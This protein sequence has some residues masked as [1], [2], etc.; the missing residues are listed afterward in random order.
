MATATSR[1]VPGNGGISRGLSPWHWI[2]AVLVVAVVPGAALFFSAWTLSWLEA[3]LYL[4]V[5]LVFF[6]GSRAMVA[7]IHPDTLIERGKM[8]D[9]PDAK[10]WDKV[11]APIV[12]LFGPLA[13]LVV[14]GL[15]HRFGWGAPVPVWARWTA[16][17]VFV[18]CWVIGSWALVTNRFFSG[19]VRIQT[20]RGHTV[21]SGG[22]YAI[23]R[24]PGYSTAVITSLALPVL[25]GELWAFLP[26]VLTISLLVVR[27]SLEDRTLRA[28]LPGYAE[29]AHR[30]R[31][32]LIPGIW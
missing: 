21:V 15:G 27:T 17:G 26:A 19:V 12:G 11:L 3:W 32:R 24:H 7:R 25:L 10:S 18:V 23:V 31:F 4:G 6:A 29:Y 13:T 14:G 30:T 1:N 8:M 9:H 28:E 22:P 2:R 20:D 5:S 16:L